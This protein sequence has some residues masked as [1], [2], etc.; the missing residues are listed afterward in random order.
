MYDGTSPSD[1]QAPAAAQ[2]ARGRVRI[3]A[4]RKDGRTRL[5][6]LYQDGAAKARLPR[7]HGDAA[8]EAV[9][10]NTAGGLTGGDV[11]ETEAQAGPGADLCL[12]SQA[13]ER[14]YRALPGEPPARVSTSLYMEAGARLAWLP[15]ETILF[16]GGRVRRKLE[17]DMAA[18][19][20]LLA[21]EAVLFGRGA[22]G[23]TVAAG[24]FRD[25]WRLRRGGKLVFA[26]ETRLD[27]PIDDILKGAAVA[28]GGHAVATVVLAAPG[29]GECLERA[30][31]ILAGARAGASVRDG[32]LVCR[33]V[34]AD[35]QALR[36][37][38]L[39][40]LSFLNGGA[41]PRVWHL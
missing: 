32:I 22:S 39:P 27:G 23:E 28:A 6:T 38:L 25:S 15:Q 7:V 3:A 9:L 35:G 29:A 36:T 30:R 20:R 16:D 12:T 8:L 40:L 11:I 18:D 10:L 4:V 34:A 24:D 33:L 14:I 37:H 17:I 19:G 31:E 41:L 13:C 5:R 26:D 21:C 1:P 2:R